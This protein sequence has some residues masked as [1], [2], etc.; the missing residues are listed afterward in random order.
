M[1][2]R[3]NF[4]LVFLAVEALFCSRRLVYCDWLDDYLKM[5]SVTS[6]ANHGERIGWRPRVYFAVIRQCFGMLGIVCGRFVIA[7]LGVVAIWELM[8]FYGTGC[9]LRPHATSDQDVS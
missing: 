8:A 1:G 9:M 3:C 2:M 5:V 4:I 7:I 6:I